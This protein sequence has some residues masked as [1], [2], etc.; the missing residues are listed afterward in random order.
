MTVLKISLLG[1]LCVRCGAGQVI[2]L[3]GRKDRALLGFLAVSAGVPCSRERLAG[4][5]WGDSGE[6]QARDSLK[7]ALLRLR[8]SLGPLPAMPLVANR[9]SVALDPDGVAVDIH[10]FVRLLSEGTLDSLE[11]A[12]ALYRGD[13]LEGLH[14]RDAGFEDWLQVERQR[15]RGLAVE[16]SAGLMAQAITLGRRDLAATAARR[17]LSLEPLHEAACRT[18]MQ[19]HADRGERAQALKL[20]EGLRDRLRQELAVAPEPETV[21][22]YQSLRGPRGCQAPALM[23]SGLASGDE[24]QPL[25]DAGA[26]PESVLPCAPRA[27]PSIAVLPFANIGD[28]PEQEYFADGLTEDIITDLSR[29][30]GLFVASRHSAFSFKGRPV[31]RQQVARELNVGHVL[32]GRVRKVANRVRVTA[33]LIDGA[34]G[35]HLW[36]NRYDR[37][38]DDIFA[39][40]DEITE[41]IVHVLKVTLLPEERAGIASHSTT[42]VDAYQYYLMGRSFYLRG[43]DQ[44]SLRIAREMFAKAIEID[45]HYARAYAAIAI[46]ESYLSMG[47]PSATFESCLAHSQRAL[48]LDPQLAEAQALKGLMLYAVGHFAEAASEFERALQLDPD[49]FET[50]FFYGRSCRLQGRHQQAAALFKRAALLRPDDYRALGLLAK[51]YKALGCRQELAIAARQCLERVETEIEIHPDNAGALAFGSAILAEL[52][53][54]ERAEDWAARAIM[55]GPDDCVA[56]YNVAR[57]YAILGEHDVAVEWLERAFSSSAVW[58]DRLAR[59]M[60]ADEDIVPLRNHPRFRA[61]LQRLETRLGV[62][63]FGKPGRLV[64]SAGRRHRQLSLPAA[65][66]DSTATATD[67]LVAPCAAQLRVSVQPAFAARWLIRRLDRFRQSHPECEVVL[68]SAP[69]LADLVKDEADLAIRRGEGSWPGTAQDLLA[70]SRVAPV[71][72]PSLLGKRH[73]QLSP[74][75][76]ADLMLLHDDDGSLWRCWFE[77]AGVAQMNMPCGARILESGLAIEAAIAGQGV[78]LADTFLIAEELVR[79]RLVQLSPIA[80]PDWNYYLVRLDGLRLAQPAAAF[81]DWLLAETEP[82]RRAG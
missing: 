67:S 22:L 30:S 34:T 74:A 63:L 82:L 18:L 78:V 58:Q 7:Q 64:A 27:K 55:I 16:A 8:R 53:Q 11:R 72:A 61:F 5:L 9:Q 37:Q 59:W 4:L 69:R 52:G 56:R 32:E 51:S 65:A 35:G 12:I 41:S 45:P 23:R 39:L 81:R 36:A 71:A 17:L 19:I 75:A 14:V 20:F 49:L 62:T 57:T 66:C 21:A 76:I 33:Q 2:E 40:Q 10:L 44:H 1:G 13:L 29:V 77:A 25:T 48:E 38:L 24:Q 3:S 42:N 70:P 26:A 28:D 68:D 46:C 31:Q 73:G 6:R 15:L 54:R 50:H 47:D 43:I 80:V 60:K 79:R